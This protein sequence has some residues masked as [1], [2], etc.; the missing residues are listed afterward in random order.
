MDSAL[1]FFELSPCSSLPWQ[2]NTFLVDFYGPMWLKI[3]CQRAVNGNSRT[4]NLQRNLFNNSYADTLSQ[5]NGQ[6]WLPVSHSFIPCKEC[7]I[8]S[9]TWQKFVH[10]SWNT[11]SFYSHDWNWLCSSIILTVYQVNVMNSMH[12]KEIQTLEKVKRHSIY[13]LWY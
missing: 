6:T 10:S 4:P 5:T 7:L 8:I 11:C 2:I 3:C 9:H 1:W 13:G 12:D